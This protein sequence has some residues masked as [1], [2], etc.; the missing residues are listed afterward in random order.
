VDQREDGPVDQR[1]DGPV[2]QRGRPDPTM[3]SDKSGFRRVIRLRRRAAYARV[4]NG[5]TR[6]HAAAATVLSHPVIGAC[7]SDGGCVAVYVAT[8]VE[9][10]TAALRAQLRAM[11]IPVYVPWA[12]ADREMLWVRDN[13]DA[14][15]WGVP[16]H[17]EA[18]TTPAYEFDA[19]TDVRVLVI[20][21]L[22]ATPAGHRLGQGGGYYDT[23][24]AQVPPH[25]AGGPLRVVLVGPDELVTEVPVDA[26]DEPVDV[27]LTV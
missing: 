6:D 22:A 2:D 8:E 15:A 14:A 7:L 16:G 23:L 5:S 13:G 11:G 10:P 12:R 20:P 19:L 25:R 9:P 21:A 18:P 1:E 27:V 24:L 3:V 4:A 17:S 26:H